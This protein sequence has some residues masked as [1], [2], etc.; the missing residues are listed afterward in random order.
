MV[1]RWWSLVGWWE[2]C[3]FVVCGSSL[4][5]GGWWFLVL[6]LVSVLFVSVVLVL[7]LLLVQAVLVLLV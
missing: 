2:D 4:V 7:V 3:G 5:F 6:V 1:G